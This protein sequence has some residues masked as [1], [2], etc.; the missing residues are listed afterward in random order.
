MIFAQFSSFMTIPKCLTT[1]RQRRK[2]VEE[3][4]DT[5][6]GTVKERKSRNSFCVAERVN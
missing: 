6:R 2:D 4:N 3:A 5:H 1:T